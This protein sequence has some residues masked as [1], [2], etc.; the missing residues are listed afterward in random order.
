MQYFNI[1]AIK[2]W[3]TP[4]RVDNLLSFALNVFY[5]LA[6]VIVTLIFAGWVRRRIANMAVKHPKLDATLFNFLANLAKY[7]IMAI[8][9]IFILG[10]FGIQ[11][12][13][14]AAL[15]GAAGLAIG[16]A[17]QGTLSNLAAGVMLVVF[18]P[19]RIGDL[20]EGAGQFGTVRE[21]SL[22]VTELQTYDGLKVIV[23]NSALWSDSIKNYSAN[24]IRM[25]DIT[26]G[27]S[28]DSDLKKATEVLTRIARSDERV[29]SDPAPFVKVKTL[30]ESSVDFAFRVWTKTP[31]WWETQCDMNE[32][33]KLALDE[34]GIDIPFPTTQ[35]LVQNQPAKA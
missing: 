18:R 25:V 6:I 28:Y 32:R 14:L 23:S 34:A 3:F 26:V 22:F 13:S 12:T 20:I 19:F 10:R 11:T 17:L 21:I 29:L 24:P 1:E 15:L 30:N 31:D 8:A 4:A 9:V 16:L 35:M 5:A 2:D 33:I 27:V 7:L